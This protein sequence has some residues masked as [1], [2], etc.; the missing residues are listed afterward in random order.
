MIEFS[1]PDGDCWLPTSGSTGEGESVIKG[2]GELKDCM[3]RLVKQML[4]N[5]Y[6]WQKLPLD[7]TEQIIPDHASRKAYIYQIQKADGS[8]G[9]YADLA[10]DFYYGGDGRSLSRVYPEFL[11]NTNPNPVSFGSTNS[12][13]GSI[14]VG[15]D[16]EYDVAFPVIVS[17]MDETLGKSFRFATFVNIR[18]SAPSDD[19]CDD[20]DTPIQGPYYTECILNANKNMKITLQDYDGNPIP[21]A[22]VYFYKPAEGSSQCEVGRTDGEGKLSGKIINAGTGKLVIKPPFGGD[23]CELRSSSFLQPSNDYTLSIPTYKTFQTRF[24][25]ITIAKYGSGDVGTRYVITGV[26]KADKDSVQAMMD[27]E[28]CGD[29]Y[30]EVIKNYE[31]IPEG[32][33]E[34]MTISIV[35]KWYGSGTAPAPATYSVGVSAVGNGTVTGSFALDDD[36]SYIYIYAPKIVVGNFDDET[37]VAPLTALYNQCGVDSMRYDKYDATYIANNFVG[38]YYVKQ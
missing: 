2:Y 20:L 27:R 11:F 10:L 38:C 30:E 35:P 8:W 18:N 7:P 25:I 15:Y 14:P 23:Y 37:D 17:A 6:E 1:S 5:T 31:F 13:V 29:Q 19:H 4:A 34:D 24:Y 3:E 9:Q 32:D 21:S 33:G 28:M 12:L 16:V 36:E 22:W 26:L